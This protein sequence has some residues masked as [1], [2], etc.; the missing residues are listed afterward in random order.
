V[1]FR[2][3]E[4]VARVL[5]VV[6][7]TNVPDFLEFIFPGQNPTPGKSFYEEI[8]KE[9][10][11]ERERWMRRCAGLVESRRARKGADH[12]ELGSNRRWTRINA[13]GMAFRVFRGFRVSAIQS[14]GSSLRA[15]GIS[16]TS[17][18]PRGII[19]GFPEKQVIVPGRISTSAV[20]LLVT[21]R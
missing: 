3:Y 21:N 15:A 19:G 1:L 13:D 14:P 17:P 20:D 18:L 11:D 12:A 7:R 10:K 8:T 9:R 2:A 6:R 4:M 16:H 5:D